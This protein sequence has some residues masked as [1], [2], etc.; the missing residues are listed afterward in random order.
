MKRLL[1]AAGMLTGFSTAALAQNG[2]PGPPGPPAGGYGYG[3]YGSGGYG[4][5]AL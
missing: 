3:Y 2:P 5:G 1:I 4:A